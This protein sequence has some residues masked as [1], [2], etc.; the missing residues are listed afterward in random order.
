ML[1][2][3]RRFIQDPEISF[4]KRTYILS[5]AYIVDDVRR[6]VLYETLKGQQEKWGWFIYRCKYQIPTKPNT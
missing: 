3:L 4:I 1:L 5:L 6:T 2:Q